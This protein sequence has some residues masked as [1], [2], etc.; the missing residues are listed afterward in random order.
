MAQSAVLTGAARVPFN[1]VLQSD[2]G[3]LATLII[4]RN[5][6]TGPDSVLALGRDSVTSLCDGCPGEQDGGTGPRLRVTSAPSFCLLG[7]SCSS[8]CRGLRSLADVLASETFPSG[9]TPRPV[10]SACV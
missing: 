6:G 2:T 10:N 4:T 5:L 9:G 1:Q 7:Q 3:R 8:A